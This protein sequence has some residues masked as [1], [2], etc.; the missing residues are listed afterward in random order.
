[1]MQKLLGLVVLL[2]LLKGSASIIVTV[3]ETQQNA[4]LFGSVILRCDYSTSAN[5]QEVLVTWRFKSFCRD[6]VLE[7]YSTA[8]QAAL[9][10]G[11]DPSNDCPDDQRTVR[12]VIQKRGSS[13]P[14]LG[15]EYRERK[16]TI[17]NK[18][19][20]V[21]HEVM[22]RDNGVYFCAVDAPGDTTGVSLKE[23]KLIVYRKKQRMSYCDP[24]ATFSP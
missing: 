4:T 1:M 3:Q 9:Q 24:P 7:Y 13:K 6:P 15:S 10:L 11:Q 12:T 2:S 23:T 14:T 20:L 19:D 5:P 18:A 17:Q 21:I 16:I 22:R 8:Y